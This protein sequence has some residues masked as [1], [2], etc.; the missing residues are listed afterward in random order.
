MQG[1]HGLPAGHAAAGDQPADQPA[2]A[3]RAQQPPG[4]GAARA[5]APHARQP[6]QPAQQRA[7]D[8]GG[9]GRRHVLAAVA[10]RA[11]PGS[12]VMI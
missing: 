2:P 8:A 6:P 9:R 3:G 5:G 1:R 4:G 11:R 7:G 10:V 12:G